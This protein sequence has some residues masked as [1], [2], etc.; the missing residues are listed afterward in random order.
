MSEKVLYGYKVLRANRC[1]A[2]AALS[3]RLL[4][5]VNRKVHRPETAGPLAV[6]ICHADASAFKYYFDNRSMLLHIVKCTYKLSLDAN[7]WYPTPLKVIRHCAN[8][9]PTGTAFAD[10]VTCKE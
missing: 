9:W 1:S 5:P 10:F 2:M 7:L 4:Y 8:I 6:F 3:H